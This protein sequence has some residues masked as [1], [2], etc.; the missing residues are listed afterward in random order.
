MIPTVIPGAWHTAIGQGI[1]PRFDLGQPLAETVPATVAV[2]LL[3]AVTMAVVVCEALRT[4]RHGVME[5]GGASIAGRAQA[6]AGTQAEA[7]FRGAAA[8]SRLRPTVRALGFAL[9]GIGVPFGLG[10]VAVQLA[11]ALPLHELA[12]HPR[13]VP[14][15]VAT[16]VGLALI[17]VARRAR[18]SARQS[19]IA[20]PPVGPRPVDARR[21]GAARLRDAA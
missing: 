15:V 5:A 20:A 11:R 16:V 9:L 12:T 4:R 1:P 8:R 17:V 2:G 3:A 10:A 14:A 19:R 6:P 7:A 13:L 21:A 18:T